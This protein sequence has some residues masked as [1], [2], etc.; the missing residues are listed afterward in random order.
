V[1]CSLRRRALDGIV[2]LDPG[3]NSMPQLTNL[4]F[5]RARP[6]QTEALG[7]ALA[8][9]VAPTRG[10][11]GCLNYDLYQSIENAEIWF[12]YENWC[13]MQDLD[14]HMKS[15]HLRAFL[16]AAPTLVEGDIDLRRFTM[17]STPA[18]R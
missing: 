6:G 15:V 13:S 2:H 16:T 10:E 14:S 9:L 11:A 7:A 5:F 18:T 12:V 3:G 17:I 8:A 1:D 4:A